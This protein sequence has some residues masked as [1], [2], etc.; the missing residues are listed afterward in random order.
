[1]FDEYL[2][3]SE[4]DKT[5]K[6]KIWQTAIGLQEVDGLKPSGYLLENAKQ[7]IEGKL[8]L[9]EVQDHLNRYYQ[10]QVVRLEDSRTEEADKVATRITEILS[11]QTF[12]LSP[13]EFMA[14]HRRLFQDIYPFAGQIRDYNISKKEWI[15]ING[16]SVLYATAE[17]LKATLEYDLNQEKQFSYRGLS[18]NEIIQH[19]A[20]FTANLWQIHPFGEGN[21]RTTAVFLI[22]YLRK[23]GFK[24]VN[25][26]MFAEHSLYFRNALVRAN[27]ENIANGI[28]ATQDYLTLFLENLLIDKHHYLKN[29]EL[30]IDFNADK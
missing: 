23:L 11:E 4:P 16:E 15:L 21:T 5:E 30:H 8:T 14:I 3:Q 9:Y 19:I 1:M 10:Q 18:Q 17:S 24:A 12:S 25:N 29:R 2:R 26:K 27:Y 22:K 28:F 13:V 20:I 7:H 6:A